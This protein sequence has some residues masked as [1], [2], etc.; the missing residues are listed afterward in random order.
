MGS[1][2]NKI[3]LREVSTEIHGL[4]FGVNNISRP[5]G[6]TTPAM[7]LH[8]VNTEG[9]ITPAMEP[10][11]AEITTPAMELR[12]QTGQSK[13]DL[14]RGRLSLQTGP[15]EMGLAVKKIQGRWAPEMDGPAGPGR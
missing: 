11:P 5:P 12:L 2:I 10:H 15:S 9:I 8:P 14:D 4:G 7:E 3:Q 6:I 13:M 1:V